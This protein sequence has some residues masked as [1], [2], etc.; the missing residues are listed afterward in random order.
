MKRRRGGCAVL[1]NSKAGDPVIRGTGGS[2]HDTRQFV[3]NSGTGGGEPRIISSGKRGYTVVRYANSRNTEHFGFQL[4]LSVTRLSPERERGRE[5]GREGGRQRA[6][7]SNFIS[8]E[9]LY[10]R[11]AK[12]H[13][14]L[15]SRLSPAANFKSFIT[16]ASDKNRPSMRRDSNPSIHRLSRYND[17]ISGDILFSY[18]SVCISVTQV[19]EVIDIVRNWKF[20]RNR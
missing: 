20:S 7:I 9:I 16:A 11:R 13:S 10:F 2:E 18:L 15:S 12:D 8:A 19:G 4:L 3:W 5:G 6:H 1:G 17:T 14:P